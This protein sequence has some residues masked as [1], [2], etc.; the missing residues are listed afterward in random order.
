MPKALLRQPADRLER[1]L[2][3]PLPGQAGFAGLLVH[4]LSGLT[5]DSAA[6]RPDDLSRLA[7]IADDLLAAFVAHHLDAEAALSEDSRKRTLVLSIEAFVQQH[8]HDPDLSPRI[9]ADAN[10]LSV[11]HLHRLF[12]AREATVAAWIRRLRL[13]RACRDLHDPALRDMP[14]HRIAARWGFKD[15]STF[16]RAFRAAYDTAPQDYRHAADGASGRA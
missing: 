16:T 2:A 13:E 6:Y 4:F 8:L 15:H 11:G 3:R 12:S 10:H 1:L 14:V 9:I 7:R 5:T